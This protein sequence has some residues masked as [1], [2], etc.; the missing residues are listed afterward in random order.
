MQLLIVAF[1]LKSSQF[2]FRCFSSH[3]VRR[4]CAL[5]RTW[6]ATEWN[7]TFVIVLLVFRACFCVI[8]IITLVYCLF[9]TPQ[10]GPEH[11][12]PEACMSVCVCLY[13]H[14]YVYFFLINHL[15]CFYVWVK[16]KVFASSWAV[17][18][19]HTLVQALIINIL[20][21]GGVLMY[22]I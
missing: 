17:C 22:E 18:K 20:S 3:S 10:C 5:C 21:F 2:L 15:L 14:V 4:T 11:T 7:M 6:T 1:L 8:I 12:L 19:K 16:C 9:S 13:A